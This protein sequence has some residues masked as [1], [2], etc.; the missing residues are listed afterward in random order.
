MNLV[1]GEEL[2]RLVL[3]AGYKPSEFQKRAIRTTTLDLDQVEIIPVDAELNPPSY[4]W[5]SPTTGL[6]NVGRNTA[7]VQ[8]HFNLCVRVRIQQQTKQ[9]DSPKPEA[10]EPDLVAFFFGKRYHS[11]LR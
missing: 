11:G 9:E 2:V 7:R 6:W 10:K 3:A 8:P 4:R 1:T 5:L